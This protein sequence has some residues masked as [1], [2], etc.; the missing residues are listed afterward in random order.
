MNRHEV[1]RVPCAGACAESAGRLAGGETM[2]V[3]LC[4]A[5]VGAAGL[6]ACALPVLAQA[7]AALRRRRS[8]AARGRRCCTPTR[9]HRRSAREGLPHHRRHAD[10][11][12][13][14]AAAR[15]AASGTG[16]NGSR[17]GRAPAGRQQGRPG[18]QRQR[19]SEARRILLEELKKEEDKLAATAEGLQQRRARAPRRRTQLPALPGPRG[20][21]EGRHH[22]QGSRHFGPQAR[23]RQAARP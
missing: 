22:A 7:P 12:H 9:C 11:H 2:K 10:H 6:A 17:L 20:R 4:R 13:P 18:A 8:T 23:N 21:D 16:G 5:G 3:R 14:G 19:D 15:V 1:P